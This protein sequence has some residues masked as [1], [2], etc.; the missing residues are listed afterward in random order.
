MKLAMTRTLVLITIIL[1]DL[2]TGMEFDLFV[3]SF[4]VL[5]NEF[6]LSPFMVEALL[7]VNFI[8]YC[9]SLFFVGGL[10]DRFG[11][12][13]IILLGLAIFI[14]GSI[15]CLWAG[16]YQFLLAGRM[17]Q[18]IGIAPPA[19]L[20]F[21][22]IADSYPLKKQQYFMAMLNGIMNISV[23]LAPVLGSYVTLYFHWQGNFIAL[24]FLGLLALVMTL[25]FIPAYKLPEQ[26]QGLS[27]R[28]Y[29]PLFRSKPLMLLML[30]IMLMI[31]PY[32][33]FVG[34]APLL[35]MQDLGVS[36]A[37]FGYYQ[38]ALALVF[39]SGSVLFGLVMHR[40][41]QKKILNVTNRMYFVSLI[42]IALV[43]F[44]NSINPIFITLA[45]IPF[46]ISQVIPSTIL[47]PI[48]LGFIPAAKGKISA[49][50]QGS[51]LIFTAIGLQIAGYFY[52]GSFRNIGIIMCMV[53]VGVIVSQ[54]YVIRN[55]E[56]MLFTT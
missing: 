29:I 26:K 7:S 21:L 34:M 31:L 18:G 10:A 16:S 41:K 36:L 5:Q 23:G 48:C 14:I 47:Y 3:P 32:W 6:S 43:T 50:L 17:L 13:Q 24:L 11:R 22:I 38:G 27:F 39:A 54:Y 4:P 28:G 9:L 56:I 20:S 40:Y 52:V 51:R 45:F 37:H 46:I 35:Y 33:I 44:S 12:K 55:R 2:L 30:N 19:I 49:T 53:I 25:I 42:C 1:M 8:G 15:F